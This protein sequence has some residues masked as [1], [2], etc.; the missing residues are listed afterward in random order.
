MLG[1]N[2]YFSGRVIEGDRLGRTIGF[3]TANLFVKKNQQVPGDGIF[4][5][6]VEIENKQYPGA[7]S[8]GIRPVIKNDDTRKIEVYI[9]DFNKDIYGKEIKVNVIKKIRNQ[10][11]YNSLEDLKI[12]I[13]KDITEI[14]KILSNG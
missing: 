4:V 11:K 3:P 14:K 6:T 10:I 9:L 7:L 12:Q 13:K 1:E 8:I 2:F 5:S